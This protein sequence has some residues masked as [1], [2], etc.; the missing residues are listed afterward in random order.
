[1][2]K[3]KRKPM[4]VPEMGLLKKMKGLPAEINNAWRKD[5]S[6]IGPNTKAK[7][8]GPGSRSTFLKR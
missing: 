3:I 4:M 7:M 6:R 1:M 5:L 2:M 8:R